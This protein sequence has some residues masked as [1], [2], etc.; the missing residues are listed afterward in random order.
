[1]TVL[2]VAAHPDDETLGAGGTA[3]R[4]AAEGREV[5]WL[6]LGEGV[7]SRGGDGPEVDASLRQ[8]RAECAAAAKVLG[9]AEVRHGGLPD[10]RFDGVE[11]LEV[12]RM[13]EQVVEEVRP[14]LVITHHPGDVNVDHRLTHDAVLAATR[15]T[16]G[17][18]VRT[19]MC[20]EV[21]SSTE[22]AFGTRVPFVP[23]VFV[24]V[25]E[26]IE[27]KERALGEYASELRDFPHPRSI[28]QVR[29]LATH[30]GST[31]GV[32]A[33]E[34]FQLVRTLR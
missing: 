28:E 24:D 16:A 4:F 31:V 22:W 14:E 26:W 1:M 33:A 21:P 19:V 9:V 30:R 20:F 34:A 27:A 25:S 18:P 13:V 7:T 8:L 6:V 10:N 2:V 15:P 11:L 23:D 3:A 32:A 29:A 5:A 12:V 17:H